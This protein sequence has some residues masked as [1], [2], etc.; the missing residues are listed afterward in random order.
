[1]PCPLGPSARLRSF[2]HHH[3]TITITTTTALLS[4]RPAL[5]PI[6]RGPP[7]AGVAHS[8]VCDATVRLTCPLHCAPLAAHPGPPTSAIPISRHGLCHSLVHPP[9]LLP[10]IL[11]SST[12]CLP[13]KK[14]ALCVQHRRR[15]SY[16]APPR[17]SWAH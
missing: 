3:I 11:R 4:P 9:S 2:H 16:R 1:M 8:F 15:R 12:I 17:G 5:H 13:E 6:C 10:S 14:S 7:P